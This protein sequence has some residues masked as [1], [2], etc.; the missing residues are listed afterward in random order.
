MQSLSQI[1]TL[2]RQD[3]EHTAL[4]FRPTL[5][6]RHEYDQA[7]RDIVALANAD[8]RGERVIVLGVDAP[9][10]ERRLLGIPPQMTVASGTYES[11]VEKHIEPPLRVRFSICELD[12]LR[13]GVLSI[14]ECNNP[15]Y[16]IGH[17]L[18]PG[19]R[20]GE[21]WIRR[22]VEQLP[23]GR[24][25]FDRMYARRME[26]DLFR[27]GVK[28][29]FMGAKLAATLALRAVDSYEP[30]S[31]R[32][33]A[34]LKA[35]IE[36]HE[37]LER[38][39]NPAGSRIMRLTHLRVFGHDAPYRSKSLEQ[40]RFDL[41]HLAEQYREEDGHYRFERLGHRVNLTLINR[42]T[43]TITDTAVTVE[44]PND[45]GIEIAPRIFRTRRAAD[46]RPVP[47]AARS[48][49]AYPAVVISGKT[50]RISASLGDVPCDSPMKVFRE[51]LRVVVTRSAID[52]RAPLRVTIHGRNLPVPI[53]ATLSIM[54]AKSKPAPRASRTLKTRSLKA[55]G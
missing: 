10:G 33:A 16:L 54:G 29:G 53:V 44:I 51:P 25:D 35:A 43:Q 55:P 14:A 19:L 50:I 30:P 27:G 20:R 37:D 48:G 28:V 15:P 8:V 7:L 24:A 21:G 26:S 1:E 46:E 11:L 17:P 34:R 52:R 49:D 9:A 47:A 39:K 32:A 18:A 42:G 4:K 5:Y 22:G 31:A 41:E 38:V 45:A 13:F 36:A 3:N 23:L 2:I 12:G 6:L 40:L